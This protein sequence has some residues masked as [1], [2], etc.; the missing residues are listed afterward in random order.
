[1]DFSSHLTSQASPSKQ[2]QSSKLD[3]RIYWPENF[4]IRKFI[5]ILLKKF[6]QSHLSESIFTG[7]GPPD[8]CQVDDCNIIIRN[9]NSQNQSKT[10]YRN[11]V[12]VSFLPEQLKKTTKML[13]KMPK[14][15]INYITT[16]VKSTRGHRGD[17]HMLWQTVVGFINTR[18]FTIFLGWRYFLECRRYQTISEMVPGAAQSRP[19]VGSGQCPPEAPGLQGF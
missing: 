18:G 19:P 4:K 14:S 1:M 7:R 3:F 15:L 10:V 9:P 11:I 8:H 16:I 13:S 2:Y 17:D 5:Q 12:V 6:G